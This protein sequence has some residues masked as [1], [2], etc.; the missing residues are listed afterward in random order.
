MSPVQAAM[1]HGMRKRVRSGM[2]HSLG[3][4][5]EHAERPPRW[6]ADVALLECDSNGVNS[7]TDALT[8]PPRIRHLVIRRP[9]Q[10]LRP[11]RLEVPLH[12]IA[13]AERDVLLLHGFLR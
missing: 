1:R 8:F 6:R 3:L 7:L 12:K 13:R 10:L 9:L 5:V 4:R 11:D 2:R